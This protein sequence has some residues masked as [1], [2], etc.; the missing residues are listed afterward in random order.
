[1]I[2][3]DNQVSVRGSEVMFR[4]GTFTVTWQVKLWQTRFKT[5]YFK[6]RDEYFVFKNPLGLVIHYNE[7]HVII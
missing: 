1:M 6:L 7:R 3:V 2:H 4:L 5:T